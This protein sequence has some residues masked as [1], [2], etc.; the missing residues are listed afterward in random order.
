MALARYRDT[1]WF[2]SGILAGG[3]SARVFPL[4]SSAPAQLWTDI[5]GTVPLPNPLNTSAFG[6]LEFWA[7]EGEYW[8]HIDALSFRVSVGSPNS[9][10]FEAA[11]ISFSTGVLSGGEIIPNVVSPS[12]ID[13]T[14]M[15]GYVMDFQTD[16][17]RPTAVRVSTPLLTVEMDAGSLGRTVTHWLIDAAGSVIQQGA[18]PDNVQRRQQIYIGVTVQSGG[19]ITQ[20]QTLPVILAQPNN[21]FVDLLEALG[22]FNVSGNVVTPNGVNL[23]IDKTSGTVFSRAI[24]H[25]IMGARTDNP[26]VADVPSQSPVTLRYTLQTAAPFSAHTTFLDPAQYDNAGVLTPV[27]GGA[28]TSTIQRVWIIPANNVIDQMVIQYGQNTHTSLAAA[29]DAIGSGTFVPRVGLPPV[30]ALLGWICMT[31]TATNLSDTTQATFVTAN[32]F[33]TP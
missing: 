5:T 12:A 21:Q 33:A 15:V 13:I 10:V 16:E 8:I 31:R 32:K 6:V 22:A 11:S 29:V 23:S 24:N 20:D 7:E 4:S 26:H 17:I 19:V 28:N 18:R 9:D 27:G 30:A 14:P 3:V 2:P 25:F 1:F